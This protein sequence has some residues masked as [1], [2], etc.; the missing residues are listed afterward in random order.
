MFC[1]VLF[2]RCY[3]ST[4]DG[5]HRSF[6]RAACL[7]RRLPGTAIVLIVAVCP[8]C[9]AGLQ[10]VVSAPLT[11][12]P[13]N[14]ES[15]HSRTKGNRSTFFPSPRAQP[16]THHRI[17]KVDVPDATVR[18]SRICKRI[19]VAQRACNTNQLPHSPR[20]RRIRKRLAAQ[21]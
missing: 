4:T 15:T 14:I 6:S 8:A 9:V 13:N 16:L 21:K 19:P 11:P 2:L 7:S 5:F 10:R 1:F 18:A 17:R 12:T 3:S 20:P